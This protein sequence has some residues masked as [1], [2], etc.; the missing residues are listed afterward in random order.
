MELKPGFAL[1]LLLG[2]RAKCHG[3]RGSTAPKIDFPKH[4]KMYNFSEHYFFCLIVA[5]IVKKIKIK[6]RKKK[7]KAVCH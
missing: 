2:M 7:L 1:V 3:Y 4:S 6:L 5:C